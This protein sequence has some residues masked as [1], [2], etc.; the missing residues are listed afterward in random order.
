M[1]ENRIHWA[2]C[3]YFMESCQT[4]CGW[5][6]RYPEGLDPSFDGRSDMVHRCDN[7]PVESAH[8]TDVSQQLS[9]LRADVEKTSKQVAKLLQVAEGVLRLG[10]GISKA[11]GSTLPRSGRH[12]GPGDTGDSKMEMAVDNGPDGTAKSLANNSWGPCD[13]DLQ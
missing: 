11:G 6:Q 13:G 7:R 8:G 3:P 12:K 4:A 10:A 9:G 5:K 2:R 1:S